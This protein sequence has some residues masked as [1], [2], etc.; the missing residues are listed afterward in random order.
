MSEKPKAIFDTQVVLRAA[1]NRRSLP[2]RLFFDLRSNYDLLASPETIAEIEDVLSRPELRAKFNQL[3]DDTMR[4]IIAAFTNVI[5][6]TITT[7]QAISRDPKDD[8]FLLLSAEAE[9]SYIV[10]E[11]KDLLSLNNYKQTRILNCLDFL[12]ALEQF[13]ETE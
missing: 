6:V 1:I 5:E 8:I 4:T 3:T 7:D 10:T 11:D 12:Q 13:D 2:A 9:A